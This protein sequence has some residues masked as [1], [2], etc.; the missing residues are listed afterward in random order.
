MI[1][2]KVIGNVVTSIQFKDYEDKKIM[3]VQPTDH[4]GNNKGTAFLAIDAVQAGVGDKVLV[5]EEGNSGREIINEKE[6]MTVK[7]VI[8]AII[9]EIHI[10]K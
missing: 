10:P 7:C 9:D 1:I 8:A 2:G 5:L 6:S 3:F 4:L